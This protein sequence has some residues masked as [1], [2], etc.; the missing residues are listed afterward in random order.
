MTAPKQEATLS[1]SKAT[2]AAS[3]AA[4]DA[5]QVFLPYQ[6]A[7]MAAV[8]EHSVIVWEKS[9]RTG[10]SWAAGAIAMLT[11][12]ATRAAG[13]MDVL[14]MGYEKEMTREFI[15]YVAT[16]AK[17][18]GRA[19]GEVQEFIWTDPDHP[20]REILAFRIHFASGF[21]VVALPS[22]ARALRG[23]Q[24]LVILDEAAFHDDLEAVLKAAFALLIWGG[25]VVVISTHDGDTN[26]FNLLV[27]DIRAGRRPYFL[28]RTTF[29]DGLADGLYR[30]ICLTTGKTWSAAAEAAW[31][32]EIIRTYGDGADEELM[33]IP[34]PS[35]GTF[36]PGPLIEA[37]M[38]D[39]PVL[40]WECVRGFELWARH[41]REA[42]ARDWIAEHLAAVLRTL[43]P[44]CP[45][46]FGFDIARRGDLT[47]IWVL[48][49]QANL[50]KRTPFVVEL[51]NCP[52]EQQR[53]I[54]WHVIER[55]PRRRGGHMD[56][57]GLGMQI[58]EETMQKF[59]AAIVPV[60]MSE[61]WYRENMPAVKAAFE[62]AMLTV[63]RDREVVD[64][65]RMLKLVRGVARVPERRRD[66]AGAKRHGDAAIA[67][68]LAIAASRAEPEVYDYEAAR[69]DVGGETTGW[70]DRARDD[71][72]ERS[73]DRREARAMDRREARAMGGLAAEL[74]G[75]MMA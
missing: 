37:R 49:I 15:D 45:H 65:I 75:R 36:I 25:K 24:G 39:A 35:S 66:D 68:S 59:G 47:V 18:L 23:K 41:L 72:D 60:M 50:E 64:D 61:P 30:R 6:Q 33:V 48:A 54:L 55:L 20:E 70:R 53:Q 27:Q 43:D 71:D 74:R 5:P 56:A 1:R 12:S 63:P 2:T 38:A 7:F 11:A 22:V 31:R 29:D 58:A 3:L 13:G 16:W 73:P 62:D 69:R 44:D 10:F 51:R 46:V 21:E 4:Q 57:T 14:Y 17:Q 19:A 40:R 9:R 8:D 32:A 52:F 42:E 26:P 28:G 34:S 67:L